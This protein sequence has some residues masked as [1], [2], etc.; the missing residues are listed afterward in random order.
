MSL[1]GGK[2]HVADIVAG[3][4]T[5]VAQLEERGLAA[6]GERDTKEAQI[7]TLKVECGLLAKEEG[8]A[9]TIAANL[10]KLLDLDVA[11]VADDVSA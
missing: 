5:I 3:L 4:S 6:G 10:R 9:G 2:K 7:S 1:F 8:Q 11:D